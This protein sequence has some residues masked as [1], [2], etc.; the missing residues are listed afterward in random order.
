MCFQV[1]Q[2][3][4][5]YA[6]TSKQVDVRQLKESLWHQME[7]A[8]AEGE[9]RSGQVGDVGWGMGNRGWGQKGEEKGVGRYK[10]E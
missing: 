7:E 6:R 1:E 2:I 9:E 10:Y 3:R 8:E 4:V 5:T